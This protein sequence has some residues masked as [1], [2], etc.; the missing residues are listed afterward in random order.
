M[1]VSIGIAA[2]EGRE[3]EEYEP[4]FSRADQAMYQAK[5]EGKN[6]IVVY[7]N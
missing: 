3:G 5:E 2:S 4:L 7:E 6:R 1:S